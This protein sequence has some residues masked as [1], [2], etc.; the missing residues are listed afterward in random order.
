[1]KVYPLMM[2]DRLAS[3]YTHRVNVRYTDLNDTAALTK[4]L[5]IYPQSGTAGVGTSVR[6]AAARVITPFVGCATLTLQVGDGSDTDR[7]LASFDLKAAADTYGVGVPSTT[8]SVF[9]AADTVDALFTATTNNL[10]SLTAGEVD[11]YLCIADLSK[12]KS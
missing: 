12:L 6:R 4:T 9:N 10:T 2:E 3:G 7:N 5:A 1:M 8:P 11:I